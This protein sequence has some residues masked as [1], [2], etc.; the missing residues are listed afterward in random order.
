MFLKI[1]NFMPWH[2]E[3]HMTFLKRAE[4]VICNNESGSKV[5]NLLEINHLRSYVNTSR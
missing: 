3:N 5:I 1:I 4:W 2:S